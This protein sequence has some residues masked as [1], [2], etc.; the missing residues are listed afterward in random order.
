MPEKQKQKNSQGY[1]VRLYLK[2]LKSENKNNFK[3]G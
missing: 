1:I 2:N 3:N